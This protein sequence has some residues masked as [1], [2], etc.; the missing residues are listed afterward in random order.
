LPQGPSVPAP[1][2]FRNSCGGFLLE[3][4]GELRRLPRD[5]FAVRSGGT[6]RRYGADLRIERNR[7]GRIVLRRHGKV[8]WSSN[9]LY[10]NDAATIAFGPNAFAFAAYRRGIFLTDLRSPQRLI[11]HG[12]G[13]HP[14][15]FLRDG[16]L[17]VVDGGPSHA[18][19]VVSPTGSVLRRYR[20]RVQNGYAFDDS[21]ESLYFV[22]PERLLIRADGAAVE[23]VRPL[24][25]LDG[26]VSLA[27]PHLTLSDFA[28][29][30]PSDEIRFTVLERDGRLVSR[31]R[32]RSPRRTRID[33]GPTASADG[34]TFAFRT[35]A[36][37]PRKGVVVYVLRDGAERAVPVLRHAGRQMGCGVGA[38]FSWHGRSLLYAATDGPARI[39][40]PRHGTTV[41]LTRI[42][43]KLPRRAQRERPTAHWLRDFGRS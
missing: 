42:A 18:V 43:S 41:N 30:G 36:Q 27:G 13:L 9:G 2:V 1:V 19:R 4:G 21:A 10:R 14:L 34:R 39:V 16:S 26:W 7:P 32:W 37:A 17:L 20:Y 5:W 29:R 22:T 23:V 11:V 25:D 40:D 3:R 15:A 35:V 28:H 38:S 8:V 12:V 33:Y 6:G 31:W 24:R